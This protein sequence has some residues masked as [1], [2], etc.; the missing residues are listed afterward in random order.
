MPYTCAQC[1]Q[2]HD[3]LPAIGFDAP[4]YYYTLSEEDKKKHVRKLTSDLCIL[5][6]DHQTDYFIRTVL[7]QKIIGH[8]DRL[9]YGVWVTLSEKNFTEYSDNFDN[10]EQ[11]GTYY[12]YLSSWIPGYDNTTRVVMRVVLAGNGNRPEVIPHEDEKDPFTK[13]YYSG[14][15]MEEAQARIARAMG[16][17][18]K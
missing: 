11:E 6:Y 7:N 1:G 2:T 8:D 13:D 15:T 4:H 16:E 3:E 10:S 14:I 5:A 12:G 9:Q 17:G 18:D